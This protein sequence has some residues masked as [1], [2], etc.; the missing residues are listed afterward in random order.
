MDVGLDVL[1]ALMAIHPDPVRREQLD[2]KG[3]HNELLAAEYQEG[4]ELQDKGLVHRDI[5]PQ[6][7]ML[8]RKGAKLLDFNIASRVGDPVY[9]QSGTP[10]YQ[11]PDADITRREVST[12]LVA[13]GVMLYELLCD[14]HHPSPRSKP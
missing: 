9:T 10:A 11:A 12:E 4:M 8:T 5:K 7:V 6:N 13:V 14:R 2:A 1:E 3:R